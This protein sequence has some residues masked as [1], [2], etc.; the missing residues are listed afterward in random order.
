MSVE[1]A[2]AVLDANWTGTHTLPATG[3]YPHQ[4]SWDSG[5]IAI[6][7]RHHRPDRARR[8]LQSLLDAQWSDGRIPQIVYDVSRDDDYAPG[9]AFWRSRS[10]AGA[11]ALPSSGLV[12]PPNHAL[13]AWLVHQAD[14]AGSDRAGFLA[15]MHPRL[16]A[17]HAYLRE[18]RASTHVP[19]LAVVKHPWE[20]GTDNSPLW[21][22]ALARVPATPSTTI[23]RPDL[24]HASAGERPGGREY[25]RFYWLAERYRDL[26]CDDTAP[27][28]FA[29]ACPMFNA[30]LAS[31]ERALAAIAEHLGLEP[32]EH[33]ERA[34]AIEAALESLWHDELGCYVAL[35][36]VVGT[37]VAAATVNGLA[38]ILLGGV[39]ARR[40]AST[41][42]GPR[43]LGSARHLP[44]YDATAEDFDPAL[45]WRG[46]SWFSMSW[47]VLRGAEAIGHSALAS[48]VRRTFA[49]A[50]P[51][52][53]EY[54]DP[55]TG[56]PRGTRSFSWT[57]AL[58]IDV[59]VA[60]PDA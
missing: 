51:A 60:G 13:A 26:G 57:A 17:W 50:A 52:F 2:L 59:A 32:G 9:D 46:P 20:P 30:L 22:G 4:W 31:S 10:I 40:L 5:F 43:F 12:Q 44:S 15:A 1:Q 36:D 35:D 37:L 3:L 11:G 42:L 49:R 6:G 39:R 53:P 16:I 29:F 33:L 27:F 18:R 34:R 21:D 54:V 58:A 19:G 8:E 47:L 23:R 7:L 48:V 55:F 56:A 41:A 38:P 24:A 25:A 45:Y 14:P 28:P